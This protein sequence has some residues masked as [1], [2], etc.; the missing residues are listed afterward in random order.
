MGINEPAMNDRGEENKTPAATEAAPQQLFFASPELMSRALEAAKIG[1]WSCELPANRVTWSSNL[2]I[3]HR[4][5]PG[6]ITEAF[7]FFE[8]E[9]HP[10]DRADVL[11]A[12]QETIRTHKPH[13]ALYRLPPQADH[14]DCWI[15]IVGSVVLEGDVPVRIVGT[16]RDVTERVKLHH[17][18]RM[19]ATQQE[20]LA[21]LGERALTETDLQK[22]FDEAVAAI[23]EILRVELVK[24]LELVPG[25]AEL[26]L[27]AARGFEPSLIGT[28][29]VP[30]DRD[31]QAGFTLASGQPVVVENLATETRFTG[32][33]FLHEHG[34]VSGISATIAGR[35]GRAYGVLTAHSKSRRKFSEYDISFIAAIANVIAAAIQRL[36]L[37]RRHELMIRELRHRSGNLFSQLLALFSQTARNSKDIPDLVTKYEARVL[38]IANAHRLV[39]EGGWKAAS[40]T[41][42]LNTLLAPYLD[43]ISFTGPN[44]F[45][46]P[47]ATFGLSMAVHELASNA[48]NYGSLSRRPGV[49]AVTWSVDRTERGLTL[50][51]D[52]AERL[53]P[54]PQKARRAGFGSQLINMV[55]E[56]QLNGEVHQ[57]FGD[58]G[59]DAK[60]IVPLTHERW[61]GSVARSPT[62]D[63]ATP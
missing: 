12:I 22:F 17:E 51:F 6:T 45:L 7:S 48:S 15:E 4:L 53:G 55:I 20:V 3:I 8:N 44:V 27:R 13:R 24:I 31:T 19:R 43:R 10:E 33:P 25:D 58:K 63:A 14:E 47:D 1:I 34:A 38:A 26:I 36:Q 46:E 52:W 28:I 62:P 35:D 40:L 49:V 54:P 2:E 5:P 9:M 56:R 50:V 57:T 32:A 30:T 60:L 59:F 37:D 23:A 18:L 21:R 29:H 61:P 11:T 39:S 16:C 41:E 42:L